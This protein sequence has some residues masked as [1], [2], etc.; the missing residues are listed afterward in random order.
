ASSIRCVW[1]RPPFIRANR[2][3]ICGTRLYRRRS[4]PWASPSDIEGLW[5]KGRLTHPVTRQER[6][7]QL[8]SLFYQVLGRIA[9][10]NPA[11]RS[12]RSQRGPQEQRGLLTASLRKDGG[13]VYLLQPVYIREHRR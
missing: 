3:F 2:C 7:V 9:S 6:T 5:S 8:L 11:L 1:Q 4:F 12:F 13:R 10:A